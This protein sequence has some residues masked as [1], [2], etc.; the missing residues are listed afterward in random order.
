MDC[1]KQLFQLDPEVHYLNCAYMAPVLKTVEAAGIS[2]IKRR[3]TPSVITA[4]DFFREGEL[5]RERFAAMVGT[6]A[7]RIAIVPSAS[8]GLASAARNLPVSTGQRIVLLEEQF[9]SN[10]YTWARRAQETDAALIHVAPP[11]SEHR[12]AA[13]NEAVLEAIDSSTAV[14][15]MP[16]YHWSDGTRFDLEAIGRRC[17]E[18]GAHL[19]VD[20]TQSVGAAPFD[21][22]AIQPTALICASYKVLFGPYGLGLAYMSPALDDGVPLEENWISRHRS[23]D[24]ARLVDYEEQYRPGALRYDM[25]ERSNPILLPMLLAALEQ[26]DAWGP[27]TIQSY[28]QELLRGPL[29]TLRTAGF[30]I[31]DEEWRGHHL[32]GLRPPAHASLETVQAELNRAHVKVSMRGSAIRVSPHVYNDTQDVDALVKAL[33]AAVS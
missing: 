19:I 9:P 6:T 27:E 21:L 24:F 32:L 25:G 31:E 33:V 14:V 16:H 8:Y 20:G 22:Q 3:H 5:L 4:D 23:D 13:W 29:D 18:V 1:Q 2:G 17:R 7:E 28:T 15:A 10:V 12:G 26:V 30:W 11:A